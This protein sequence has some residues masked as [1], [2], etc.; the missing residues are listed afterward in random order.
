MLV[1][2]VRELQSY[3]P[4]IEE[5]QDWLRNPIAVQHVSFKARQTTG[6]F[7]IRTSTLHVAWKQLDKFTRFRSFDTNGN[8]VKNRDP[9]SLY[10]REFAL[11]Q[12]IIILEAYFNWC[13]KEFDPEWVEFVEGLDLRRPI[14]DETLMEI[15]GLY[16]INVFFGVKI[17]LEAVKDEKAGWTLEIE[18]LRRELDH[19]GDKILALITD[20]SL[21]R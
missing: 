11:D 4:R 19:M 18:G 1:N 13:R 8:L 21:N 5:L 3:K 15:E 6:R 17:I 16:Y 20:L 12:W 9:R 10:T 7:P 2:R 14:S